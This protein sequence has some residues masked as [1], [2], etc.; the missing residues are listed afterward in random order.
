MGI[1]AF[2]LSL[3]VE[4]QVPQVVPDFGNTTPGRARSFK[5]AGSARRHHLRF[6][7]TDWMGTF[8]TTY[9]KMQD[10]NWLTRFL[11]AGR[12]RKL[13]EVLETLQKDVGNRKVRILDIGCGP[14]TAVGHILEK[15]D[16]EYVGIDYDPIFIDAARNRYGKNENC[17][18]IVGDATDERLYETIQADI[19][20]ALETLEHIH[21]NRTVR[22]IEHVCTIIRP[23]IFLVTVPVEVGPAVWIK[24][25]GSAL[26]GYNR[27]SGNLKE[28]FWAGLYRMDRVPAHHT[29]HQGFDW[30]C[31]AQLIRVNAPLREIRS[32]PFSFV[33][34]LLSP[35]VAL[36]AEPVK[37]TIDLANDDPE[38]W[39]INHGQTAFLRPHI[40]DE[41]DAAR[42][43]KSSATWAMRLKGLLGMALA[44]M[45][46][47]WHRWSYISI[48]PGERHSSHF[49]LAIDKHLL[50]P[51]QPVEG[52]IIV[53]AG[54]AIAQGI[55]E[56]SYL[57][58]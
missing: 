27:Q 47:A 33:P 41:T 42:H 22:V 24:N 3:L 38:A 23:R 39:K 9:E 5:V 13:L 56:A 30:R 58:I 14:G 10:F 25:W 28:T 43:A 52:D 16:V 1:A 40:V 35:N 57:L 31:L 15:F 44:T 11:H 50:P 45:P 8:A 7:E 37:S 18:F 12:Y 6:M 20:I 49:L 4:L 21:F 29:S 19:V 46:F 36:I 2:D 55:S 34:R 51:H 54:Q 48:S 26:M 32:L 53:L 17:R